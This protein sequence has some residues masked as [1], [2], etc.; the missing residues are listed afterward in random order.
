MYIY[1]MHSKFHLYKYIHNYKYIYEY[2]P[3]GSLNQPTNSSATSLAEELY[4]CIYPYIYM[5]IYIYIF[6]YV[7]I[8]VHILDIYIC[9]SGQFEPATDLKRNQFGGGVVF[10]YLPMHIY[11]YL[12]VHIYICTCIYTCEYPFYIYMYLRAVRTSQRT[13]AQRVWLYPR[14][15]HLCTNNYTCKSIYML[16]DFFLLTYVLYI[17]IHLPEV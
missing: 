17:Y 2:V 5:H 1:N 16:I 10:I 7:Y 12:Y 4:S 13:Q 6:I 9:T 14:G 8:H 15:V 11:A 3:P